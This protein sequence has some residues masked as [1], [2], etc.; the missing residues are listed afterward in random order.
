MQIKTNIFINK[1][2]KMTIMKV[3]HAYAWIELPV[4]VDI[5][6]HDFILFFCVQGRITAQGK[7]LLQDTLQ[8]AEVEKNKTDYKFKE[9]HVFQFDQITI[10]SEK[11]ERKK[12]NFSNANYIYKNS[13]KVK[14]SWKFHTICNLGFSWW[15]KSY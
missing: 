13:L 6:K 3:I 2:Y 7:L 1:N 4:Q 11:I 5:L 14:I 15:I 12:G 9:R 10:F 8:V